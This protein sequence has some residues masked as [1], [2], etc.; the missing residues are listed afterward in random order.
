MSCGP[1][2]KGVV[3][4]RE[5]HKGKWEQKEIVFDPEVGVI[6]LSDPSSSSLVAQITNRKKFNVKPSPYRI[7]QFPDA[8]ALHLYPVSS[9][10]VSELHFAAVDRKEVLEWS[11]YFQRW[12]HETESTD[13]FPPLTKEESLAVSFSSSSSSSDIVIDK[14]NIPISIKTLQCLAHEQWLSD[15]VVN[16]YLGLVQER[17]EQKVFCWNSFFYSKL[18]SPA[19]Y[20]GVRSWAT[21][22]HVNFFNSSVKKMLIPIHTVDHWSLGLV[23]FE[24]KYTRYFDSLGSDSD[25]FH[26]LVMMYLGE[27]LGEEKKKSSFLQGW[28][29]KS[30]PSKLPLQSNGS[31]CGVFI[32]MYALAIGTGNSVVRSGIGADKVALM[33]RR[34]AGDILRGCIAHWPARD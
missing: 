22:R 10:E 4:V 3:L 13:L 6:T 30:A 1:S 33:R 17:S 31:D 21:K 7:P 12:M 5:P 8:L 32:C 28:R 19:G 18:A 15:E 29:R 34:I 27:E 23:H 2:K 14:F 24:K 9:P 26:E 11:Y 16:F 20:A 25:C